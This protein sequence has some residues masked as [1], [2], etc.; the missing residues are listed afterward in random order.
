MVGCHSHCVFS[1]GKW[2]PYI[3][4]K[5][6]TGDAS[7]HMLTGNLF[8]HGEVMMRRD[9]YEVVG[10]YRTFFKFAQ[11]RD[12]F[13]RLSQITEFHVIEDVLYTHFIGVPGSVSGS[14]EKVVMQRFLSDFACY[15]HRQRLAGKPDPLIEH[16]PRAG[17]LWSPGKRTM[18]DLFRR[19][20]R[21]LYGGNRSEYVIY[22][23]ALIQQ[24][25]RP[26]QRL[27][28][29]FADAFPAPTGL[30]LQAYYH[31]RLSGST[32]PT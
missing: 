2:Q 29:L 15:C 23:S 14:A 20:I 6:F 16:G 31:F 7:R 22:K 25:A 11:D 13:C 12:L 32:A 17:L 8:H 4:A 10:G 26:W 1:D 3:E 28:F 19:A 27:F 18:R 30:V 9:C 21:A 24:G 5:K